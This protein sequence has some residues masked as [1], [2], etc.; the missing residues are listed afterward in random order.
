ML[1]KHKSRGGSPPR[2]TPP[3]ST[4]GA[5][6][7]LLER[8]ASFHAFV[9]RRVR[10]PELAEDI[11]QAAYLRALESSS[12]VRDED[13]VVAW[14]YAILRNAVVDHFRRRNSER[15][16][17]ARWAQ[18]FESDTDTALA[19]ASTRNFVCGCIEHVLPLLRPAYAELL[20]EIDLNELPLATFA[21]R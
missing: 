2:E 19:D 14:F 20:R 11:L 16:A 21:E 9:K 18:E 4:S 12:T 17:Y 7:N 3:V 5:L 8:R 6:Q 10:D 1:L 15:T 13:S